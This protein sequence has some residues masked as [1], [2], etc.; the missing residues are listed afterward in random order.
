MKRTLLLFLSCGLGYLTFTSHSNGIAQQG[1]NRTGAKNSQANCAGTGCHVNA[2]NSVTLSVSFFDLTT[3]QPANT[4]YYSGGHV[5]RVTIDAGNEP[6]Y[7]E[8]GFQFAVTDGAG[9]SKGSFVPTA[10]L[11]S[12]VADGIGIIEQAA[13]IP[14]T[15]SGLVKEFYWKAPPTGTGNIDAYVTVL[16]SNNDNFV[17][18]DRS[19]HAKISF[20]EKPLS[21]EGISQPAI[22]SVYPNPVADRLEI[23]LEKARAGDYTL[24]VY[25]LSG[26]VIVNQVINVSGTTAFTELNTGSWSSGTYL[27]SL[28]SS[29][30]KEVI[31]VVKR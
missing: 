6:A 12:H 9:T 27:V 17:T 10:G 13:P 25:T 31:P 20:V 22:V 14:A 16:A 8:F 18:G 23:N 26:Q 4:G 24:R 30:G 15:S 21:I 1:Y 19:A 3:S 5:Y 11:Q 28:S 7:S 29:S 2:T